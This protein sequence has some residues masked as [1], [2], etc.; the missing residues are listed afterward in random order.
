MDYYSFNCAGMAA[1]AELLRGSARRRATYGR[2]LAT[3]A[4][5]SPSSLLQGEA[6]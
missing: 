5:A 3:P 4:A 6:Q 2:G 1:D